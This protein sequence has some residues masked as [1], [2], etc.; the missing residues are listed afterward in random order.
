MREKQLVTMTIVKR[1]KN[2]LRE[3]GW[4]YRPTQNQGKRVT[5]IH[6]VQ[7]NQQ[8]QQNPR[9]QQ[10]KSPTFQWHRYKEVLTL[11][12]PPSY[13]PKALT[14]QLTRL[15]RARVHPTHPVSH[16]NGFMFFW[17]KFVI[18]LIFTGTSTNEGASPVQQSMDEGD[19]IHLI[20]KWYYFD[21]KPFFSLPR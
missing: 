4:K 1:R 16:E 17:E 10:G 14:C 2:R 7:I 5:L 18:L 12:P 19:A 3:F 13:Q 11:R 21:I 8:L 6:R 20:V 9:R 15:S